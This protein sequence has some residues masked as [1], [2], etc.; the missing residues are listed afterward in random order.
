MIYRISWRNYLVHMIDW[1]PLDELLAMWYIVIGE[2]V[3]QHGRESNVKKPAS[4]LPDTNIISYYAA[5]GDAQCAS[6]MYMSQL[7]RKPTKEERMTDI[8]QDIYLHFTD[9]L[10]K[11][12]NVCMVYSQEE[13]WM[14]ETL[15]RYLK[16]RHDIDVIDLDKLFSDG[17]VDGF[18]FDYDAIVARWKNVLKTMQDIEFET[19]SRTA[20]GRR[21]LLGNMTFKKKLKLLK[22]LKIRFSSKITEEKATELLRDGWV[23]PMV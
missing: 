9:P 11:H 2:G 19:K 10:A 14:Q 16:E 21:E 8:E 3:M 22:K 6:G 4:L 13:S 17:K 18:Y 7:T 1:F 20:D 12:I 5:T 15:C 23:N